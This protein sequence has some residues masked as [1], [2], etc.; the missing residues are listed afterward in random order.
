MPREVDVTIKCNMSECTKEIEE[1][2]M[3]LE[4]C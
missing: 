4:P 2:Y 3:V 1:Q